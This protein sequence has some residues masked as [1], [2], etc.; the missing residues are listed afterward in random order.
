LKF[1]SQVR[2]LKRSSFFCS[3]SLSSENPSA[4]T[5]ALGAVK[6]FLVHHASKVYTGA[7][8]VQHHVLFTVDEGEWSD[9]CHGR[10]NPEKEI[11]PVFIHYEAV[12]APELA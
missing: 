12:L 10:R 5:N 3:S 2:A 7:A 6:V 4:F 1:V 9:S 8:E 11:A